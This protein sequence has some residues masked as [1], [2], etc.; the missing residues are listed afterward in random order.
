M[1]TEIL[2]PNAT[3]DE[4]GIANADSGAG[5]HWQDV[6]EVEADTITAVWTISAT[7]ERD[8]YNLPASSES[9]TISKI[10]LYWRVK[11]NTSTTYTKGVIKSDSTVTLTAAKNPYTDF[12]A[13]TWGTYSNIWTTNPADGEAWEQTDIDGLQIGVLLRSDGSGTYRCTQVYVEVDYT[14]PYVPQLFYQNVGQHILAIVGAV[15]SRKVVL[16]LVGQG[17]V[18]MAG[19]LS[20]A[21]SFNRI[22]G[23]GA[24]AIIGMPSTIKRIHWLVGQ[25]TLMIRGTFKTTLDRI[26]KILSLHTAENLNI[27]CAP[28]GGSNM[29]DF[30]AGETVICSLGVQ[31][32]EGAPKDPTKGVKI[33]I[34]DP[35]GNT[36]V[37]EENMTRD[38]LG[39][40]HHDYNSSSTDSVGAYG[41][42]YTTIDGTRITIAETSFTVQ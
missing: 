34:T 2:R 35:Q 7:D 9:G 19:G 11:T 26:L 4:E 14:P 27:I 15:G 42:K 29:P 24:M 12:G 21:K 32:E 25:S 18:R 16:G 33:T 5:N 10:T 23:Q 39:E 3:G 28:I 37:D 38:E 22:V 40:Y 1:V 36:M 17:R 8:L 20:S 31:D 13:N 30:I 6:D 41:V